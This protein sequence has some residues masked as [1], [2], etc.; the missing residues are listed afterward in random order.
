MIYFLKPK[1]K[2]EIKE[3]RVARDH[4]NWETVWWRVPGFSC[5][6]KY[7]RLGTEEASHWE[8]LMG[9]NTDTETHAHTHKYP[10]KSLFSSTKWPGKG[11]HRKTK[12]F[13]Q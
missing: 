3:G 1:K 2:G 12:T 9:A 11:K 8:M 10:N 7:P 5:Y 13:R 6:L 4:G